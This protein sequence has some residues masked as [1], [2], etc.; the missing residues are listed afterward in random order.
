MQREYDWKLT[1]LQF[2]PKNGLNVFSCFACGGGST[3]GYKLA[4][5]TVLGNCDID[6][7]MVALYQK[8][9]KPSFSY[10]MDIREFKELPNAELPVELFNLDILDGSPPC[11]SFSTAGVREEAWGVKKA[12][13]EGQAKQVL[14]DLFFE[15]IEVAEKLKPKVIVA[16]NVTG[17]IIGKAKGYVKEVIQGFKNI[18]YDV[19]LF[20]LNAA[21]MGVPQRRE[22]IFFIARQR[23]LNLPDLKLSFNGVPIPY[24]D[25]RSGKGNPVNPKTKT[26]RR[27]LKRIP[28]DK[29]MGDISKRIEGKDKNFNTVF[30]KNHEVPPTLTAGGINIRY[31]EPFQI[32]TADI[33]KIQSFPRDYDFGDVNPQ[34]VCG[35]SVPPV[36]TKKIAEQIYLQWFKNK[37]E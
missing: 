33:V 17:M 26:Y 20:K 18:G 25:I 11:S 10:C 1:D 6:P 24:G 32:S 8:N 23:E 35:M 29:N 3:M 5:F 14:D 13:R 31:D 22:R 16:E 36:M 37:E 2:V 34:Y 12:F 27:W 15:F 28:A 21:T 30:V 4:G 7:Q 9:H 19:Q